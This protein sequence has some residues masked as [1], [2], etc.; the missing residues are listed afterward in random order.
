MLLPRLAV[1]SWSLQPRDPRDLIEKLARV[2][3]PRVQLA[4]DPLR[5]NPAAWRDLAPLLAQN[6]ITIISGML[7][8]AGEDY[9]T[10]E[11]IK[12]TGGI[13]PDATWDE[14]QKNFREGAAIAARLGIKLIT[15]HAGFL[16][17]PTAPGFHKIKTRLETTAALLAEHRTTLALETGQET[18]PE[19]ATLLRALDN[20]T[21]GVNF[22]PANMILYAK[23]DP[24]GALRTL[25][26]WL[27]QIHLKDAR[28]TKH[29]G[30]WGEELPI[31]RG[32]IDWPRFFATLR[33]LNYTGDYAIE[34]EAGTRRLADISEGRDF[35]EKF[36]TGPA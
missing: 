4:L 22:D 3:I 34:C 2:R 26:P 9:T 35:L 5:E 12:H 32:D 13:A 16:P 7:R 25:A 29:P 27:R 15:L 19:L 18:A 21:T 17:H 20:K 14:N 33:D 36:F 24:A 11:T 1:C 23:G 31:G 8:C 6:N 28:H 10:L 30:T